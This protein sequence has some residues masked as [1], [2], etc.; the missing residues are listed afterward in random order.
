[1][2]INEVE[3]SL[4]YHRLLAQDLSRAVL[5]ILIALWFSRDRRSYT[6][7]AYIVAF[8][9]LAI[10]LPF[11]ASSRANVLLTL[12]SVCV[13]VNRVRGIS[14][15]A[16]LV[17]FGA[18]VLILTGMLALRRE[19]NRGIAASESITDLGLEPLFGNKNFA[20]VVKLA[21]VYKSVPSLIN[22]KYG[23]TYLTILYA[24]I[25][26]TLWQDKPPILL[27]E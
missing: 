4:G 25:P 24:P 21:H 14:A 11:M 7:K 10:M 19:N 27:E 15:P 17:A 1:M 3:S 20:C 12:I 2:L 26:R 23:S 6:L 16:L 9:I 22:Y 18:C 8:G 5:L 13:V